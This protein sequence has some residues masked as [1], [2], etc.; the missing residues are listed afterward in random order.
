M[1]YLLIFLLVLAIFIISIAL[2]AHNKQ[3]VITFNY[4]IAQGEYRVSTPLAILFAVFMLGWA[5]CGLFYLRLRI[6]LGR[7]QSK[8]K[9]LEQQQSITERKT[10]PS[11]PSVF[12]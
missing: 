1:K 7:T 12:H 3:V 11:T 6:T 9:H 4:L 8:I 10:S 5:I 2:G